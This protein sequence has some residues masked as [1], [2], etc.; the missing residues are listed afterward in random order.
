LTKKGAKEA[1]VS[2]NA[3]RK[4]GT[5]YDKRADATGKVATNA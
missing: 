4:D 3:A 5:M 1:Q 2:I